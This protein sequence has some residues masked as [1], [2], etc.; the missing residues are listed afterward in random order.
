MIFSNHKFSLPFV[1]KTFELLPI[2]NELF[3]K[4]R[5][6]LYKNEK[7]SKF[8]GLRRLSNA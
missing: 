2:F 8:N 4:W 6:N 7:T 5:E 3:H 1:C